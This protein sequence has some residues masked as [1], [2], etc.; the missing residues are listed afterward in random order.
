MCLVW[1]LDKKIVTGGIRDIC[2][3]FSVYG[4]FSSGT[5]H[6]RKTRIH[7]HDFWIDT[8]DQNHYRLGHRIINISQDHEFNQLGVN[9]VIFIELT[10][11]CQV[12]MCK[13]D[14]TKLHSMQVF[15]F[16]CLQVSLVTEL[17]CT[18]HRVRSALCQH[19]RSR[20]ILSGGQLIWI[21]RVIITLESLWALEAVG[22]VA[23]AGGRLQRGREKRCQSR[24]GS[25]ESESD[26]RHTLVCR[27]EM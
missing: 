26:V 25:R 14:V 21:C 10:M 3:L 9:V 24:A 6:R 23:W 5:P 18:T 2:L 22:G 11:S 19:M 15:S 12:A 13:V 8:T 4:S 17:P 27:S 7:I 20:G 1:Q 16:P